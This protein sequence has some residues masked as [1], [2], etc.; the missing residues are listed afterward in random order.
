[1][2]ER[3]GEQFGFW[4]A[5]TSRGTLPA[6][7]TDVIFSATGKVKILSLRGEVTTA[8][9]NQACTL[10]L[11]ATDGTNDTTLCAA[12]SIRNNGVGVIW[13]ITGTLANSIAT[14][15]VAG[16]YQHTAL[17]MDAGDIEINTSATNTGNVVWEVEY[18][19]LEAG[20]R[21]TSQL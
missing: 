19:P 7:T 8:I 20:A 10:Q 16:L 1:M 18:I 14:S 11:Q 6:T 2:S 5:Q 13:N 21:V 12:T 15:I 17:V 3:Q 4:R 9:Q